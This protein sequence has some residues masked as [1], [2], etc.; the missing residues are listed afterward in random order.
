MMRGCWP[1]P[2][3]CANDP[4]HME[5][6]P[7]MSD[8]DGPPGGAAATRPARRGSWLLVL[9]VLLA[10]A[11]GV[12]LTVLALPRIQRWNAPQQASLQSDPVLNAVAPGAPMRPLSADAGQML[13]ARVVR[14]AELGAGVASVDDAA[15]RKVAGFVQ[16]VRK[17][18]FVAVVAKNE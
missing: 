5:E 1:S 16:T 4:L 2:S 7:L 18:D 11:I 15:A 12:V 3:D 8:T 6:K 13:D 14:P 9:L 10:F 17:G